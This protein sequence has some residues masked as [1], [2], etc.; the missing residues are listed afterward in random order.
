MARRY[1][2]RVYMDWPAPY[3][4]SREQRFPFG[5]VMELPNGSIYRYTRMGPTIGIGARL[6]QSEVPDAEF[7]TLVVATG[8][9]A[10][11]TQLIITNGTTAVTVNEFA[12]GQVVIETASGLGHVYPIKDNTIAASGAAITIN[13]ADG[14]TFQSVVTAGTHAATLTKNPWLDVI[15]APAVA[16]A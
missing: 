9:V 5:Q 14:V 8:A 7:D 16:T 4:T 2:N 6:Y 1:P 3:E 12:E 15:I 11:D 13:L 10:G